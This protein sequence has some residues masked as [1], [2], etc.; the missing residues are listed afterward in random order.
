MLREELFIL[1]KV[2]QCKC[3]RLMDSDS[4]TD[5]PGETTTEEIAHFKAEKKLPDGEK[6]T[7][8]VEDK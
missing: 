6:P 5:E 2:H 7:S 4:D 1:N 8:M 3:I